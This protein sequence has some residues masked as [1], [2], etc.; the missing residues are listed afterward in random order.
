M[1]LSQNILNNVDTIVRSYI[2]NISKKYNINESE[3][4]NLWYGGVAATEIQ[5]NGES[6][7]LSKEPARC[8]KPLKTESTTISAIVPTQTPTAE[9]MEIMLIALCDFLEKR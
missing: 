9:I 2:S 3:L 8:S 1:S 5:S 6:N 4:V 7:E